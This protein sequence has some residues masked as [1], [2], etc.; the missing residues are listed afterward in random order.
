VCKKERK[1]DNE[2]SGKRRAGKKGKEK[3]QRVKIKQ[4]AKKSQGEVR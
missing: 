3:N 4:N 1:K 2:I